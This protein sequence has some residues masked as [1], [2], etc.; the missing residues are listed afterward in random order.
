MRPIVARLVV[1]RPLASAATEA[2][3]QAEF[4]RFSVAAPAAAVELESGW[5]GSLGAVLDAAPDGI[6]LSD[7]EG[8]IVFANEAMVG[9]FGYPREELIGELVEILVPARQRWAHVADRE[10]YTARPRRRPIGLGM[11]L[12]GAR[13]DGSE[14]AV[15]IS[16]APLLSGGESMT[17]SIVRDATERRQLERQRLA[18]A[19]S[20]AV[21]EIVS[22]LEVIVWEATAPDRNS[23]SYL[24]GRRDALLG[25]SRQQWLQAGFWLSIV[26]PGDRLKA[27]IL[28][29]V[30]RENETIELEYRLIDAFGGVRHV[31][32][33]VS[34]RRGDAGT[35]ER[36]SGVIIDMTER[37]ELEGRLAQSQKLEAVGQ[38]AGGI[39]HDFNNLLTIVSGY[40]GRM[41]QRP[42]LA[43]GR[44]D[45]DQIV[46]AT[47]RAAELTRQLLA[48]SRRG[49]SDLQLLGVN[50]TIHALEP[51]LRRL[52]DTEVVFRFI[53]DRDVPR[54]LMDRTELE[55]VL[56]NLIINASDAMRGGGTLTV[57][58]H[59]H[60]VSASEASLHRVA[61]GDDVRVTVADTGVGIAADECER[62]FE[63]FYTTKADRGTGMGLAT[64]RGIVE[65]AGGWI[66]VDSVVGVGT[67][68]QVMLVGAAP[69]KEGPASPSDGADAGRDWS[70]GAGSAPG[71]SC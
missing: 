20:Q 65:H 10:T 23:I 7:A 51:M 14:F 17:V 62:I 11:Q 50:E 29:E 58:T 66:D 13:K 4:G 34:V 19:R 42:D 43:A 63:P 41:R 70:W 16:L 32:D 47:D 38:L 45:I 64:V 59:T 1:P 25:Y 46:T 15:E 69:A 31:R 37:L 57:S 33:I 53:L 12:A 56:M 21:E 28:G 48:F 54:V 5:Q 6:V 71:G 36:L 27:L 35:I 40:A 55:Q 60:A 61:L 24:G 44:A 39:A 68:F 49:E 18:Y 26:H 67:T 3:A 2:A 30:A 52:I 8:R 22:A 9:L